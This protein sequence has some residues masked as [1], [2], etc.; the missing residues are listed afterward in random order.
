MAL[1]DITHEPFLVRDTAVSIAALAL[2]V[3]SLAG[4]LFTPDQTTVHEALGLPPTL[5]AFGL[6]CERMIVVMWAAY[7]WIYKPSVHRDTSSPDR[8]EY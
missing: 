7:Q 6:L 5:E 3:D 2:A 1:D 8:R 4:P